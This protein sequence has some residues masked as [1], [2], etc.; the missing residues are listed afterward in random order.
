MNICKIEPK[1]TTNIKHDQI[2]I[3]QKNEL[4]NEHICKIEPK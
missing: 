2:Q 3:W 4:K 1:S